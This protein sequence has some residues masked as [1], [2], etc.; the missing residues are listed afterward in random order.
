MTTF[1][2]DFAFDWVLAELHETRERLNMAILFLEREKIIREGQG[3]VAEKRLRDAIEAGARRNW[4][5]SDAV[6]LRMVDIGSALG[7]T[8]GPVTNGD[9]Q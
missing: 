2:R 8:D 6:G 4:K 3:G 1:D 7:P 5:D 9:H